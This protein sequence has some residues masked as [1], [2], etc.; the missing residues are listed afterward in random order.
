MQVP[1]SQFVIPPPSRNRDGESQIL[2]I[3]RVSR[4][5]HLFSMFLFTFPFFS[6]MTASES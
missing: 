1:E 6:R 5:P 3:I 4:G 2:G